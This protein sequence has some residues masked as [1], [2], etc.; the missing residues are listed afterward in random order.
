[1]CTL[2]RARLDPAPLFV[3][4]PIL[5]AM[6]KDGNLRICIDYSAL[7]QQTRP[8]EYPLP[9]IDDLLDWLVNTKCL[10]SIDLCTDYH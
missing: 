4:H 7:N 9:R 5:F 10:N 3:G 1:M 6:K 8:D 2:A